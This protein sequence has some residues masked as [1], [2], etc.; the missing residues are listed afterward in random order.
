MITFSSICPQPLQTGHIRPNMPHISRL[1]EDSLLLYQ[2]CAVVVALEIV[3]RLH[4]CASR[5]ENSYNFFGARVQAFLVSFIHAIC[6]I[7]I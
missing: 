1:C 4:W 3:Q 7:W 6:L 2:A 5:L